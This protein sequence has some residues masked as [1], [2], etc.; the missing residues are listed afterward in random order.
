MPAFTVRAALVLPSSCVS[1][2]AVYG[3]A[4]TDTKKV[5]PLGLLLCAAVL[6][7][8]AAVDYPLAQVFFG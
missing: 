7:I 1:V 5:L 3:D 2:A 8:L 4:Y 6:V